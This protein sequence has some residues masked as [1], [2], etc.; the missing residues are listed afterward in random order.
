EPYLMK[1]K[2]LKLRL[3]SNERQIFEAVWWDGVSR[4]NGQTPQAGA[5]IEIAY[6]PEIN[7]WQGNR[8]L[9]LV[10]EDIRAD[11]YTNA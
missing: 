9:Q 1:E 2:H 11:N 6:T 5:R 8:R 7:A 3:R 4:S 10:V